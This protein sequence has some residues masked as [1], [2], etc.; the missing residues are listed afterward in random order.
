MWHAKNLLNKPGTAKQIEHLKSI[1]G[2]TTTQQT[3]L[4]KSIENT[5]KEAGLS[6]SRKGRATIAQPKSIE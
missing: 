4:T 6:K 1:T 3:Q 5:A 2:Y